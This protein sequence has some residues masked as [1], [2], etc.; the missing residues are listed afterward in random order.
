MCAGVLFWVL[1]WAVDETGAFEELSV[2][3]LASMP[4]QG[5]GHDVQCVPLD[6]PAIQVRNAGEATHG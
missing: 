4:C 5:R 3:H 2:V 1:R 6:G